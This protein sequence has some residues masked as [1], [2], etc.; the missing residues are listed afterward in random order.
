MFFERLW[1]I[2]LRVFVLKSTF[3]A[4][5]CY[6][7]AR[8]AVGMGFVAR[9][10]PDESCCDIKCQ[11]SPRPY[12]GTVLSFDRAKTLRVSAPQKGLT[13]SPVPRH[14]AHTG[15]RAWDCGRGGSLARLATHLAAAC[16]ARHL[17]MHSQPNPFLL[18]TLTL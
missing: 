13:S 15:R 3:G 4:S 7:T 18:F 14:C 8:P 16:A 11:E 12:R 5:D 9:T 17:H 10:C 2:P 6:A 1:G